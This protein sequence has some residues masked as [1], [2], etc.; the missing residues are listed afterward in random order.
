MKER[1]GKIKNLKVGMT[2][3]FI[4]EPWYGKETVKSVTKHSETILVSYQPLKFGKRFKYDLKC[5]AAVVN[6]P[7]VH[8]LMDGEIE[9]KIYG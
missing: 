6:P 1:D 8:Y 4:P 3:S 2:F 7:A 5:D 9:I